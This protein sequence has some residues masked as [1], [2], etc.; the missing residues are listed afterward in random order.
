M[1]SRYSSQW[2]DEEAVAEVSS[3][4]RSEWLTQGP[5]I[6]RFEEKVAEVTGARY[7]VAVSNGT[8]GLHLACLAAGVGPGSRVLTSPL[9]FVASANCALYCGAR[10]VFADVEQRTGTLD[11]GEVS[12]A[13]SRAGAERIAAVIPVH[14]AGHPASPEEIGGAAQRA[15]A[16]VIEDAAHALGATW[17]DGA[18]NV[19]RVGECSHAAMSVFSFHPVKVITT[20]EGGAVTTN[21]GAL[22][23]RLRRLR[24]HGI[25]REPE[26]LESPEG[27]WAAEMHELGHNYRI[28][29]FQCALGRVQLSRLE[30][31]V[32]RRRALAAQ[33]DEAFGGW[34]AAEPLREAQG[35]SSARHLYVV[36]LRG[37]LAAHRARIYAALRE[38]GI[39]AQVHYRPVHLQPYYRRRFGH[40]PGEFPRAEQLG[41]EVLSL[42]LYPRMTDEDVAEVVKAFRAA[43]AACSELEAA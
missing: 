34:K 28:T 31:F 30:E 6:E 22:W 33:Y 18:G 42:P 35:V 21:D 5:A 14:Y 26:R 10:P 13:L 9:T 38:R 2:V 19:R 8:A 41:R 17:T 20:G 23:R 12:A 36:R 3:V 15:G 25:E 7:A 40:G 37:G 43:V 39:G 11:P 1:V 16:V 4:L 27:P 24:S 29:D 32:Q